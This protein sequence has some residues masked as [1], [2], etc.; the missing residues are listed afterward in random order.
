LT[1]VSKISSVQLSRPHT[2]RLLAAVLFFTSALFAQNAPPPDKAD[3]KDQPEVR[4]NYLNV[5]TPS[6]ADQKEI[7]A[8]LDRLPAPRFTQ[9]F[10]ISRGRS[11]LEN[12]PTASW[13]RIRH[14]FASTAPFIA[15]QYSFSQDEKS[16]I[17]S[18]VFRSR[19][20]KD[21]L[22]VQLENDITG[23]QDAKSVLSTDTPVGRIKLERFGK[24]SVVLA[25]CPAADQKAFEPLFARA[26]Q[27]FASY[28]ASLEIKRLVP[29][30]LAMLAPGA[31]APKRTTKK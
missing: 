19:E 22:Q 4:I 12:A 1:F 17:E 13:V 29:R 10:E 20:A 16:M 28:R 9:D 5:C 25:R 26:S 18:L 7:R 14:E 21:V 11:S 24:S 23:A 30:E 2:G 8:S 27:I 3:K 15:A 31:P 6:E